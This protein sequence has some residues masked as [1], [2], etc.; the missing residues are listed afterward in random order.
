[1]R[2]YPIVL[3]RAILTLSLFLSEKSVC[4]Q[5]ENWYEFHLPWNDSTRTITHVGSLLNDGPAGTHG[6]L[7]I[8]DDGHFHFDD[9]T[10]ITFF[11]TNTSFGANLPTHEE[12]DQI[13]RRMAKFGFNILRCHHM[14]SARYP[15]GIIDDDYPDTRHL[16]PDALDRLSY[17]IY[18]LKENGIY[19]DLN[20]HVG[21]HFNYYDGIPCPD[22]LQSYAKFAT[23]FEPTLIDLQKEY[24]QNLLTH[25]NPYTGLRFCDDPAV[26]LVEVTNENSLFQG[27]LSDALNGYNGWYHD[28]TGCYVEKLDSLW[29]LWLVDRY[30]MREALETAW[31]EGEIPAGEEMI[32]DGGFEENID[33]NWI[34][35]IHQP[36]DAEYSKDMTTFVEGTASVRLDVTAVTGT[37]WH[38]QFKQVNHRIEESVAYQVSFWAKASAPR[39]IEVAVMKDGSPWNGYGLWWRVDLTETWSFYSTSFL[40]T[41]TDPNDVRITFEIGDTTGTVWLDGVSYSESQIVGLESDE[42][43]FEGTVRR[44]LVSELDGYTDK[45]AEDLTRFYYDTEQTYLEIMRSF[46]H[47]SL[48]VRV[49]VTGTNN[50][51]GLVSIK[52]QAQM[53]Y[54]D[55]HAYWQHPIFPHDP[56][57]PEDWYIPNT[58][59]VAED[60]GGTISWL[61]KSKVKDQ[62]LTI[63][64][65]NEPAPNFYQ[66]EFPLLLS[67]YA[68][69][70]D[71]DGIFI[72]SYHHHP[73]EWDREYISSYFDVDSNPVVMSLVPTAALLYRRGDVRP[74]TESIGLRHTD[75][76]TFMSIKNF[77]WDEG[78]HVQGALSPTWALVHRI[79][80]ETFEGSDTTFYSDGT[81]PHPHTS[82]TGELTWDTQEE[83]FTVNTPFTQGATGWIGGD[84]LALSNIKIGSRTSFATI[85]LTSLDSLPI[86][87]SKVLLLSAVGRAENTGMIWNSD[88]TSVSTNWGAAPTLMQPIEASI[89]LTLTDADN[90]FV[91]SLSPT[92]E[93]REWIPA[94]ADSFGHF[95]FE[96]S[97]FYQTPWYEIE[98][99]REGQPEEKGDINGDGEIN[100]LD[101]VLAV[102]IILGT[103]QPTP[104]Q[105]WAADL[106]E[107]GEIDILDVVLIVN[108]ILGFHD[109]AKA[110]E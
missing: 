71:W 97:G 2:K 49:P 19:T 55:A 62:S 17:F 56:W 75:G 47:D 78:F 12:A 101:V 26:A 9:D 27:W 59:M 85:L 28:L 41:G 70:Q 76:E 4:A 74:A 35:E 105:L 44:L 8:S 24:A 84:T 96:I 92:G 100:I 80:R 21:R 110:K 99:L 104:Q 40:A 64:E 93:Q 18:A 10:R 89:G 73:T 69:L 53:D 90:V 77:D 60:D 83:I 36:A 98:V 23:C 15:D 81:P 86:A 103:Y 72:Y 34:L 108:I 46:I 37:V 43:P 42:D 45:R 91:F 107:D 63:S 38:L 5:R 30:G 25:F 7:E 3:F 51:Y 67:S 48:G 102:G 6:F 94:V 52:S 16:D 57:D 79:E 88:S 109:V 22:D 58:P 61:A 39:T 33:D 65:Y 29:N 106:N 68:A 11:G 54:V 87:D 13:A 95:S 50:Y 66:C 31:S 14:D 32:R 1:M 82:D 20:L